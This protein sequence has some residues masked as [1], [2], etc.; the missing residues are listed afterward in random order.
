SHDGNRIA[1]QIGGYFSTAAGRPTITERDR[2]R[3]RDAH[4]ACSPCRSARARSALSTLDRS[5][6]HAGSAVR[7][8]V[9]SALRVRYRAKRQPF[10]LKIR[11]TARAPSGPCGT[12]ASTSVCARARAVC[13]VRPPSVV[14]TMI[15]PDGSLCTAH[16]TR[17]LTACTPSEF[18]RAICVQV[19][20]PSTVR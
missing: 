11:A 18:S 14:R 13:Q 8:Q 15:D 19:R 10:A 7:C 3:L 1:D 6:A 4:W 17:L 16:A 2:E 5:G 20:A 9:L 12:N